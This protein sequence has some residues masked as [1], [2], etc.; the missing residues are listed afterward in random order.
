[1]YD[2]KCLCCPKIGITQDQYRLIAKDVNDVADDDSTQHIEAMDVVDAVDD[3]TQD[4][5]EKIV[6]DV[7]I[8]VDRL[9]YE[10]HLVYIYLFY[11]LVKFGHGYKFDVFIYLFMYLLTLK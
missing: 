9:F 6:V 10:P 2:C 4:V 7:S 8:V 5:V 1:M 3:S 11:L